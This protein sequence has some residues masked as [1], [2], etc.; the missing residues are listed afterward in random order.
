[1]IDKEK[2]LCIAKDILGNEKIEID[3]DMKDVSEW[4]SLAHVM[5]IAAV[6]EKFYIFFSMADAAGICCFGGFFKYG[7]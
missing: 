6:A 3:T 4:D 2:L 5:L 1:M 7:K